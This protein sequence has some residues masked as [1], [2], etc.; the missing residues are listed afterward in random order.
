MLG[1]QTI[2]VGAGPYGL[3]IAAHLQAAGKPYRIIGRPM[4]S[5]RNHMPKGM[6]LKSEPASSSLSDP[7]GCYTYE[8][9]LRER[10]QDYQPIG[11]PVP[12]DAFVD[13][14]DWF[15]ERAGL[16]VLDVR[17]ENLTHERGSFRLDM[18]NGEQWTAQR[19]ILATGHVPYRQLPEAL[20]RLGAPRVLHTCDI[21]EVD[22]FKGKRVIVIGAGQSSLETA[23]LLH[24]AGAEVQVL[25]RDA[26]VDFND[27][28]NLG[29]SR[30]KAALKPHSGLSLGW[31]SVFYSELPHAFRR[32][33][34]R[35]RRRIAMESYGPA[36]SWWLR[37][38]IQ[39]LKPI[40]TGHEVERV[41][42]VGNRLR[43]TVRHET[44]I[45]EIDADY[46]VAGTGYAPAIDRLPYLSAALRSEIKCVYGL[47]LLDDTYQ[48]SVSGLHFVGAASAQ[49]FGPVMRF[50]YGAKHPAATLARAA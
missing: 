43:V 10:G 5:W 36:G 25:H 38:R 27:P 48:C 30:F 32:L 37:D 46:V 39:S 47:P 15:R 20:Q 50:V 1:N 6:F 24:E 44:Q 42:D 17:L 23:V 13:Y 9:F 7:G 29:R 4:E 8:N 31:K 49:N 2:V 12:L 16:D 18:S 22:A 19:V 3:S 41:E 28:P 21:Q 14:A 11:R 34:L 40:L 35:L 33:P 26:Q 45:K